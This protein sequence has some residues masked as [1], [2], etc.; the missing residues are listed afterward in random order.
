MVLVFDAEDNMVSPF[1]YELVQLSQSYQNF[2]QQI[3]IWHDN[4]LAFCVQNM[5]HIIHGNTLEE[6]LQMQVTM[7][8]RWIMRCVCLVGYLFHFMYTDDTVFFLP[9]G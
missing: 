5:I 3:V 6:N 1:H 9:S 7:M 4:L 2:P 8:G